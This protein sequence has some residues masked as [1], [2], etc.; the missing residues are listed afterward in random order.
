MTVPNHLGLITLLILFI[1]C[2]SESIENKQ[3]ENSLLVEMGKE[4]YLE[5]NYNNTFETLQKVITSVK[6]NPKSITDFDLVQTY[7][8]MGN[9]H[10]AFNDFGNAKKCYESALKIAETNNK[11]QP[12]LRLITNLVYV[13]YHTGN[14]ELAKN[15]LKKLN[16]LQIEDEVLLGYYKRLLDALNQEYFGDATKSIE[17]LKDLMLYVNKHGM[18][19]RLKLTIVSAIYENY[20]QLNQL[21]SALQY[22]E[23][24]DYLAGEYKLSNIMTDSKKGL[25]RI[26]TKLG[27]TNKALLYQ[28]EYFRLSDSLLNHDRYLLLNTRFNEAIQQNSDKKIEEMKVVVSTQY[29]VII[30]IC[31]ISLFIVMWLVYRN[32]HRQTLIQLYK[33][34]RELARIEEINEVSAF[35]KDPP[36]APVSIIP[37]EEKE[38]T[39]IEETIDVNGK[40]NSDESGKSPKEIRELHDK[41][42]TFLNSTDAY[43]NPDFSLQTLALNLNSNTKYVS[44][45]I[46]EIS[47]KNFRSLINEYRISMA[48]RRLL[49]KKVYGNVTIQYLANSVGFQSSTTFYSVFKK[50]TGLTPSMYQKLGNKDND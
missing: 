7:F 49:D 16:T 39:E 41:I 32:R 2:S 50:L 23:K 11:Q 20:E 8:Y 36:P 27:D 38:F 17:G 14:E 43:C 40:D 28:D 33:R 4:Q 34:N 48:R 35:I 47:G 29:I 31:I 9:V 18:E 12:Q 24:Y 5:G 19:E 1:G 10:F 15:Y 3:K 46:N 30:S 13:G 6:T 37:S 26:Y 45:A 21:D 25:M 42:I 22:L 44:Q